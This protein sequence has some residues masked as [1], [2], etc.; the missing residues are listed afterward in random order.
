[1]VG[2]DDPGA[3]FSGKNDDPAGRVVPPYRG[4]IPMSKPKR[5]IALGFFDG[6]HLGHGALLRRVEEAA[7]KP[8][9]AYSERELVALWEAAKK[10]ES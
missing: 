4:V 1:M 3:P 7:D 8:L 5:V 9:S 10:E 2:R 6:V